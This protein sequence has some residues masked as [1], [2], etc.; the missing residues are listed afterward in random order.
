[1]S[2]NKYI[3]S[4]GR[5]YGSGGRDIG[6]A[7]AER[8]EIDF[9]DGAL[10]EIA[11]RDSGLQS[12][13]FAG[14]DE[15]MPNIFSASSVDLSMG[16]TFFSPMTIFN[17]QSDLFNL[18]SNTIRRI[19]DSGRG[20]VIVGRC[21]DYI[22]RDKTSLLSI[23]ITAPLQDRVQRTIEREHISERAALELIKKNDKAR[24][25]FYDF[26][27]SRKWGEAKTYHL[28]INSSLLGIEGT[29]DMLCD[30]I[31]KLSFKNDILNNEF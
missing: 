19:A 28:S 9:F 17:G 31:P 5:Q 3:I 7:V 23:F 22:L 15:R 10:L 14:N 1:M 25:H 20:C 13:F 4:I 27:S 29:T 6:A 24:A 18:Q 16:S 26:Y 21:A 12:K 11:A 8:L 2:E 30:L